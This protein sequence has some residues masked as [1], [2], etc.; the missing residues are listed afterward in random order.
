V[1]WGDAI[2]LDVVLATIDGLYG[3]RH[4][5]RYRAAPLLRQAVATRSRV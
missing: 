5:E 1:E 4:E 2:G 3:E